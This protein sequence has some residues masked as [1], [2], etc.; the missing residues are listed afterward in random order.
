M[1]YGINEWKARGLNDASK[2]L[3]KSSV[4]DSAKWI[5]A[6]LAIAA[7]CFAAGVVFGMLTMTLPVGG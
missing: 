5:S 7:L 4:F 6:T 3:N 1:I 2:L